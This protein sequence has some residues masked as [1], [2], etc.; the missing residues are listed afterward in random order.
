MTR[1]PRWFVISV[2]IALLWNL[3]GCL[4]FFADL[5]LTPDDVA[6]LPAA[7]QALYAA[8]PGWSVIATGIAVFGGTLGCIALLVKR[9]LAFWLFL[10]SLAGIIV[11]DISLFAPA[12][13]A[14]LAGMVAV[15][16][17]SIVLLVGIGLLLLS[18][19]AI[20]NGWLSPA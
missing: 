3:L 1:A 5:T 17:Q 14:Q 15:V 13:S 2:L 19:K 12:G 8:R 20:A 18:R 16:M 11:Q 9:K 4:A 7:Q 10:L 6:K